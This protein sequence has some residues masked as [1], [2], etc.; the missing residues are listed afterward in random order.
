L[1]KKIIKKVR[2]NVYF[3]CLCNRNSTS[4]N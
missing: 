3:F 1:K 4:K 2:Q